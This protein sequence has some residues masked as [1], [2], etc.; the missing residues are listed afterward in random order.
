MSL[1]IPGDGGGGGTSVSSSSSATSGPAISGGGGTTFGNVNIP[2]SSQ[3]PWGWII[4]IGAALVIFW[5]PLKKLF[6]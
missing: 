2:S 3:I 1:P 5:H 4:G 6:K